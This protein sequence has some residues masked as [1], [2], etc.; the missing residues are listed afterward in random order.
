MNAEED[1]K[2]IKDYQNGD[3]SAF[4]TLYKK[5]CNYTSQSLQYKGV[6]QADAEELTQDIWTKMLAALKTFQFQSTFKFFLDCAIRNQFINYIRDRKLDRQRF[7]SRIFEK[8][9][10]DD[11]EETNWLER[12]KG[13]RSDES[14]QDAIY[15]ELLEVVQKCLEEIT[16]KLMRAAVALMLNGL[17]I[18]QIAESLKVNFPHANVLVVRGKQLL[19]DCVTRNYLFQLP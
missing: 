10:E 7:V 1:Q 18:K 3:N 5:Y 8:Q 17:K 15:H 2:L 19:R 11:D 14:D 16:N 12:I 4:V 13:A 6:S 9:A